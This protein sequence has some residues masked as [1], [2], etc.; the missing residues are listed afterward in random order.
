MSSITVAVFLRFF[1]QFDNGCERFAVLY[2]MSYDALL[3]LFTVLLCSPQLYT[4]F[5][6]PTPALGTYHEPILRLC[7]VINLKQVRK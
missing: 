2:N 7:V 5:F 4:N 6:S 3:E 1:E